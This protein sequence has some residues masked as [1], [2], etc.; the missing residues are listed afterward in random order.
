[1]CPDSP[2]HTQAV[3]ADS[4]S[5]DQPDHTQAV[6]VTAGGA[7]SSRLRNGSNVV[8]TTTQPV[9]L[10]WTTYDLNELPSPTT[11]P[12]DEIEIP[13]D[14]L[15]HI[16]AAVFY[17]SVTDGSRF[18][19]VLIDPSDPTLGAGIAQDVD[20]QEVAASH[21]AV[22]KCS[23]TVRLTAGTIISVQ[24]LKAFVATDTLL[25]T[26]SVYPRLEI[27]RLAP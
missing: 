9:L 17:Q 22:L 24:Y 5:P 19:T 11:L 23:T 12:D 16:E 2:D 6:E 4:V 21:G 27:T 10:E 15:Y 20:D 8:I 3:A 18:L 1:M 13:N 26:Q 7:T 25:A 14:G